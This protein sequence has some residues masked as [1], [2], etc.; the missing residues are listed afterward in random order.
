VNG[1]PKYLALTAS[2]LAALWIAAEVRADLEPFQRSSPFNFDLSA[3]VGEIT[4]FHSPSQNYSKAHRRDLTVE[5]LQPDFILIQSVHCNQSVQIAISEILKQLKNQGLLPQRLAVEGAV[6]PIDI[7]AVQRYPAPARQKIV[8]NLIPQ[9]DMTGAM[10]FVVSEGQGEL[11][12]V[13]TA[14]L[15]QT[16][17]EMFR[18]SYPARARLSKELSKF[19]AALNL[20]KRDP[21]NAGTVSILSQDVE[22]IHKLV[23]QQLVSGELRQVVNRAVF[24][25]DHLKHV[26]PDQ[27]RKDFLEPISAAVDFYALALLR[28]DA[29]FRHSLE[30][31]EQDGQTTT[32]L[33][34]GGFHTAGLTER[35][36]KK[37]FSYVVI[38]PQLTRHAKMEERRYV[39]RVLGRPLPETQWSRYNEPALTSL[40]EPSAPASRN[41]AEVL[42]LAKMLRQQLPL[43]RFT[44]PPIQDIFTAMDLS[45]LH[46][47]VKSALIHQRAL[48]L[49]S[50]VS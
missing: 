23:D 39:E 35:L 19:D 16:S 20:L 42:T 10:L 44:M 25:V 37:G 50:P 9:R 3:T 32:V 17:I 2:T 14:N 11:Y 47:A 34:A 31:R 48:I 13:E 12:G 27:A 28:D 45:W 5:Y 29:L 43:M 33:V 46:P 21:R 6:G 30:L 7:R 24:A 36:K 4:Q 18:R 41:K 8:E 26:L 22:A 1:F 40:L 49:K 38:T 15:Y